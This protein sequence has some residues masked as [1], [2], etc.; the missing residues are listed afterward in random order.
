MT[1]VS[2]RLPEELKARLDRLAERTGRSKSFYILEALQEHIGDFEA[3]YVAE[4]RLLKERAGQSKSFSQE[5]ME[6]RYGV[7][8]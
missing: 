1:A 4:E 3:L 6:R 2:L 8:D 7:A 5:Q